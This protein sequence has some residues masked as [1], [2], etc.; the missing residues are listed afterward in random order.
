MAFYNP[1]AFR[2]AQ[3]TFWTTAVYLALLSSLIYIHE[4]VPRA[5][6]DSALPPGL[7]LSE[8]W[9]DL[10]NLTREYHPFNSRSNDA[11]RVW[12]L[13]RLQQILDQNSA[14]WT[15]ERDCIG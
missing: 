10:A 12:L 3:V 5:P 2:P 11:V 1:F 14:S 13:V 15:T 7:S 8:A 9:H 4:N 6:Q